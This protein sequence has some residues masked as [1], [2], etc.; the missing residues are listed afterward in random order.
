[1][2]RF[3]IFDLTVSTHLTTSGDIMPQAKSEITGKRNI[4]LIVH[5]QLNRQL[6]HLSKC[7]SFLHQLHP[8]ATKNGLL[9]VYI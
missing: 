5:F 2:I 6:K 7:S 8:L 1:M 4:V 9:H 3:V